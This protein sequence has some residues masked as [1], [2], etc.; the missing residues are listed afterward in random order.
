MGKYSVGSH[1]RL[2]NKLALG[3]ATLLFAAQVF[4]LGDWRALA[5]FITAM[6]LALIFYIQWR[7]ELRKRFRPP[8]S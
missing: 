8:D 2:L 7:R 5:L 4:L 3:G 6:T 1:R